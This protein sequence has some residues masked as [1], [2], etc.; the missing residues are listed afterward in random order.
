MRGLNLWTVKQRIKDIRCPSTIQLLQ[1]I[2]I[3]HL[4][5]LDV[6]W[7]RMLDSG[8][9]NALADQNI[10]FANDK[11]RGQDFA[12]AKGRLRR[13]TGTMKSHSFVLQFGQ[14]LERQFAHRIAQAIDNVT[15]LDTAGTPRVMTWTNTTSGGGLMYNNHALEAPSA[16][17]TY[18]IQ[19][20]TGT[21]APA[22]DDNSMETLIAHGSAAGQ[23]Q[24]QATSV[25]APG[26]VGSNID[27]VVC[28]IFV[29]G[30]GGSITLR[31]VGLTMYSADGQAATNN[32]P[33]LLAHDAV[34]QAI[35]NTEVAVVSY[36]IRTTV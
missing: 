7:M 36:V 26:L 24:Y 32:N 22:S 1:R 33:F 35:A 25:G 34:N 18:G 9:S 20:G 10:R 23:L 6:T 3:Y 27:L 14:T 29:N 8:C 5:P 15:M 28:R 2:D 11:F 31:E 19:A 21:T 13:T 16:D 12:R 30:S 17:N 4:S